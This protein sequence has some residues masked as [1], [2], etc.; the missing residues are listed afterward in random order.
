MD[1]DGTENLT[2]D[3]AH[4]RLMLSMR[5]RRRSQRGR[6][7]TLSG[8]G[9]RFRRSWTKENKFGGNHWGMCRFQLT[10][11]SALLAIQNTGSGTQWY[12]VSFADWAA[13]PAS[14]VVAALL[15]CRTGIEFRH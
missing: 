5:I 6:E 9:V 14:P 12:N 15:L 13:R 8:Y 7:R 11:L 4:Q 3:E 2:P 1:S 10:M